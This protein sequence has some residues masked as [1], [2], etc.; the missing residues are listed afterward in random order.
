MFF[1]NF[2]KPG[3]GINKDAP[4]KTGFA[5]FMD[6]LTREFWT[7]IAINIMFVFACL[8]IVTIGP[9]ICAMHYVC[10][11]IVRDEVV[12]AMSDFK[13][14]FMMNIKPGFIVGVIVFASTGILIYA[15]LFYKELLG[16]AAYVLL[17]V[18]IIFGILNV[19]IFPLTANINLPIKAIFKNSLYLS[20]LSIKPTL[21]S[22]LINGVICFVALWTY[23]V[24]LIYYVAIGF[25]LSTFI[26]MFFAYP[27]I[28]KHALPSD[29][30]DEELALEEQI[31][32]YEDQSV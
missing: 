7:I 4:K 1:R 5:L 3:P 16:L 18:L 8:P 14:G 2:N 10:A 17:G 13:R 6:M 20:I 27:Q 29:S 12:Y 26:N 11:K 22:F 28:V 32:E 24:S 25:S 31:V 9:A 19:Y 30:T 21:I 23:P 15:F